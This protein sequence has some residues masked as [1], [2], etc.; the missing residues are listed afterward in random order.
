MLFEIKVFLKWRPYGA[1]F[2]PKTILWT[3]A[4]GIDRRGHIAIVNQQSSFSA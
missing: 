1:Y 4:K 3:P 2:L